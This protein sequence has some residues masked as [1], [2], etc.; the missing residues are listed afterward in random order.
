MKAMILKAATVACLPGSVVEITEG[1]FRTLGKS[2]ALVTD[3]TVE[4]PEG[5]TTDAVEKK[6]RRKG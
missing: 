6:R 3:V 1:Q 2:V 5:N 4:T